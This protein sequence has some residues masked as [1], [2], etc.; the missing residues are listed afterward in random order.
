MSAEQMV[1]QLDATLA[2]ARRE[3]SWPQLSFP[4]SIEELSRWLDD[5]RQWARTSPHNWTS[6]MD[7]AIEGRP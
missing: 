3:E 7:D 6:L 5:E 4:D 1:K 2:A